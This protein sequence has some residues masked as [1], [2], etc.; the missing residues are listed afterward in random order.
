MNRDILEGLV[1]IIEPR[2]LRREMT[3]QDKFTPQLAFLSYNYLQIEQHQAFTT[4]ARMSLGSGK[5]PLLLAYA[6]AARPRSAWW[7][8]RPIVNSGLFRAGVDSQFSFGHCGVAYQAIAGELWPLLSPSRHYPHLSSQ[9]AEVRSLGLTAPLLYLPYDRLQ[10]R[11]EFADLPQWAA[12]VAYGQR[13]VEDIVAGRALK[14]AI[15]NRRRHRN[16]I[17]IV[18]NAVR[19]STRDAR[20][21]PLL[22]LQRLG[23]SNSSDK[24]EP[25]PAS[26]IARCKR[27]CVG[28]ADRGTQ[29]VRDH[30]GYRIALHVHGRGIRRSRHNASGGPVWTVLGPKTHSRAA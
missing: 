21:S 1:G 20:R 14:H 29:N 19:R 4:V 27:G 16:L 24:D 18:V 2:A 5:I 9:I 25:S 26:L 11:Y 23:L 7:A 6:I 22:F 13:L 28:S 15:K 30:N 10:V 12:V 17:S 8:P 3:F